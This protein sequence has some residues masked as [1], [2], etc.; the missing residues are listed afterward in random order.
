MLVPIQGGIAE[1]QRRVRSYPNDLA[2]FAGL[3]IPKV[4]IFNVGP[5]PWKGVG[6]NKEY[7]IPACPKGERYSKGIAIPLVV[8]SER[9]LA[10]GGNNMGTVHDPALTAVREING[11]PIQSTGVVDD[12][13]GINSSSADL[14]LHTTNG[15][16]R[17]VF[18]SMKEEPEE[19]EILLA[20]DCLRQ[21]MLLVYSEGAQRIEQKMPENQDSVLRMKERKIFNNA[22]SFL[23]YKPLYGEGE[24]RLGSC[25]EC[26]ESVS[27]AANFCKHCHQAIDPASVAARAKKRDRENA[28]LMKEAEPEQEMGE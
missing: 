25:P 14:S 13:I 28:K 24:L 15:K 3:P 16:W 27:E 11:N 10:D 1:L 2:V 21:Y 7:T 26:G 6:A 9:D 5:D 19:E 12:I 23:G 8:L 20:E 18:F 4:F 17:G 22:A